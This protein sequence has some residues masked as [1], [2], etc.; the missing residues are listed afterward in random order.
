MLNR[1]PDGKIISFL[2]L[3]AGLKSK[4]WWQGFTSREVMEMYPCPTAF[5]FIQWGPC[6]LNA[7]SKTIRK[8]NNKGL[9]SA[10]SKLILKHCM[11]NLC[12]VLLWKL[13]RREVPCMSTISKLWPF[14]A[15]VNDSL[16]NWCVSVPFLSFYVPFKPF[17]C[18]VNFKCFFKMLLTNEKLKPNV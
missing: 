1:W 17:S 3:L 14:L 2:S 11:V 13:F 6:E 15:I 5:L 4:P 16:A 10:N 8:G 12:P 18:L 7:K 9:K